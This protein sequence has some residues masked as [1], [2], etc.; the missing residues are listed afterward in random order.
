MKKQIVLSRKSLAAKSPF[1][2]TLLCIL[3]LKV[4]DFPGWAWGVF[5]TL[6][7]IFW[8]SFIVASVNERTVEISDI[9]DAATEDTDE[10]TETTKTTKSK[11]QQKLEKLAEERG[12]KL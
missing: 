7:F 5:G 6:L 2:L 11:F 10:K 4:F 12:Y 9:L 1:S 3:I 8:I